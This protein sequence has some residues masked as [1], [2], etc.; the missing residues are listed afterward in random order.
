MW[1]SVVPKRWMT[2]V[3]W[4]SIV[5]I[6]D[7]FIELWATILELDVL[8]PF[9][10]LEKSTAE[11]PEQPSPAELNFSPLPPFADNA[12]GS[13]NAGGDTDADGIPLDPSILRLMVCTRHNP[14]CKTS[15]ACAEKQWRERPQSAVLH[16]VC[17]HECQGLPKCSSA[18]ACSGKTWRARHEKGSLAA[19]SPLP[20]ACSMPLGGTS[21]PRPPS[22]IPVLPDVPLQAPSSLAQYDVYDEPIP[23][24]KRP[25]LTPRQLNFSVDDENVDPFDSISDSEHHEEPRVWLKRVVR[26]SR[27]L[28]P[29]PPGITNLGHT[30]WLVSL[31]HGVVLPIM[32]FYH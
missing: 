31:M 19:C 4:C 8:N 12:E 20:M 5:S 26:G 6:P 13:S 30:C 25:Q 3:L 22:P 18:N 24:R 11:W 28:A 29:H 10:Q 2:L 17:P 14:R 1:R 7:Y 9:R 16:W 27:P 23:K 21:V 32:M 15:A